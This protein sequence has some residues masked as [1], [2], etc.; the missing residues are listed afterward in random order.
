[1]AELLAENG[2]CALPSFAWNTHVYFF[3][4]SLNLRMS[5]RRNL[6]HLNKAEISIPLSDIIVF[7]AFACSILCTNFFFSHFT[8][9]SSA[10]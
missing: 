5:I 10:I 3:C 2:C 6:L 8:D 7:V 4:H 9:P 1:V